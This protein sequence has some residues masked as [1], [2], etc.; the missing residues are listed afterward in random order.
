[1]EQRDPSGKFIFLKNGKRL[2]FTNALS[3]WKTSQ[4]SHFNTKV[5]NPQT[6]YLVQITV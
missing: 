3:I 1:M 2:D 5:K 4:N 6:S